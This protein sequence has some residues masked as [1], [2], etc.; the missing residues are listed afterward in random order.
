MGI[1]VLLCGVAFFLNYVIDHGWLPVEVRLTLAAAAGL[2]LTTI[3]WRLRESRR[4]YAL[5]LQGGGI[6]IVYL[7]VFAAVNLYDLIG[8]GPGLILMVVL[9]ALSSALAVLQDA[10]SLAVLATLAGFLAPVLVS[11]D[12]GHVALFSDLRSARRRHSGNRVVQAMALAQSIG[13]RVHVH[14]QRGLGRAVLHT[15]ALQQH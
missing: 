3:G 6:G 13:L 2:T 15:A 12:G 7:T 4:D 10:H 11:R 14:C 9:V 1:I 5:V 8:A